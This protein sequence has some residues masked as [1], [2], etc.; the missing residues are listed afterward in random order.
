M[1]DLRPVPESRVTDAGFRIP[2]IN[3]NYKGD[4]P[5]CG[6]YESGQELPHYGPR[7]TGSN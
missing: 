1:P 4:G 6:A 5:D 3:D 7:P 2:N